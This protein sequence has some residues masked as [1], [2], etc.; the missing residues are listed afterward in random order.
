MAW[1]GK[2]GAFNVGMTFKRWGYRKHN[3]EER[4]E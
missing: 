3:N 4:K 2:Q 1:Q